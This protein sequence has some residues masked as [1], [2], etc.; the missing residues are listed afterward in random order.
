MLLGLLAA[1]CIGQF[2]PAAMGDECLA[3]AKG[4]ALVF[5]EKPADGFELFVKPAGQTWHDISSIRKA[6]L[7]S[8]GSPWL[9]FH[10]GRMDRDYAVKIDMTSE[11]PR[12][13]GRADADFEG[14]FGDEFDR[15]LVLNNYGLHGTY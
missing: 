8:V 5:A 7:I 11:K 15:S 3:E 9:V 10:L 4:I 2:D 14:Y 1:T 12:F 13:E 6:A